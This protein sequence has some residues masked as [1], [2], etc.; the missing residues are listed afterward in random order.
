MQ[1]KDITLSL[2]LVD[3]SWLAANIQREVR[4]VEREHPELAA[5]TIL[6]LL[7]LGVGDQVRVR[8]DQGNE[9][10]YTVKAAPWKLGHGKWV[11]GLAGISGG[12]SLDRVVRI[13]NVEKPRCKKCGWPL[14]KEKH[15]GC[16]PN[17]CSM[18]ER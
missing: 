11:I 13:L 8:D 7:N 3:A 6:D 5:P 12:Y 17:N 10:D 18:R 4:K 16:T 2:S 9:A 1:F 14:A 15:E